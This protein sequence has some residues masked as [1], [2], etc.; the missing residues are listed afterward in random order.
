[1]A[2]AMRYMLYEK[3]VFQEKSSK[4]GLKGVHYADVYRPAP[5][6]FQEK[7]SKRGLKAST[8]LAAIQ[9]PQPYITFKRNPLKED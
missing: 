5:Q 8:S 6:V 3:I 4:R 7:S 2:L 9:P 1:M